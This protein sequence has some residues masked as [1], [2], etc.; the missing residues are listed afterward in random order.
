M[1]AFTILCF[2]PPH[3]ANVSQFMIVRIWSNA[4]IICNSVLQLCDTYYSII[5]D[6]ILRELIFVIILIRCQNGH[7]TTAFFK[8]IWCTW[9]WLYIKKGSKYD[10]RII[11]FDIIYNCSISKALLTFFILTQTTFLKL[12]SSSAQNPV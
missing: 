4:R 2:R 9:I 6:K 3:G 1:Y 8:L 11:L 5:R 10:F 7:D 12:F